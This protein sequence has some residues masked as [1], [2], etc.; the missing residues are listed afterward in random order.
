ML[1][2]N[3]PKAI[4]Y[5]FMTEMWERFSYYGIT[6]I[7]I[8]YMSKTFAIGKD[9]IY[10]IYGA[11]GA[12]VY[13]TPLIGGRIADKY[14]GSFNAVIIGSILIALGH[15]IV[16]I[17]SP[18]N[19]Y[20]YYGLA[21]IIIGTGLFMPNINAIVGHLYQ[22]KDPKRE[23]GFTLAYMGRNIGTILAPLV[24]S[25]VAALYSWRL[26]FIVAG[27]GMLIGLA[28]FLFGRRYYQARSFFQKVSMK[29]FSLTLALVILLSLVIF[30]F[31][32][33]YEFVGVLLVFIV[34][35]M[36][37]YLFILASREEQWQRNKIYFAMILTAF[38]IVFLILLQQSGGALNLFTDSFVYK[39]IWGVH[40]ETGAFQSIEPLALV[41]LTP[42]YNSLWTYLAKHK[43]T[44]SDAGKFAWA[45]VLMSSSFV[46]MA[47]AM[48]FT[49]ANG[50]I[51][52]HWINVTYVLQAAGELFIGPIGLAMV[53]RLI[54][55]HML[56][57]Y[58]GFWVLAS[59][60][61]NFIAAKIGALITPMLNQQQVVTHQSAISSYQTAFIELS[62]LGFLSVIGL[63][64]IMPKLKR[65]LDP[66]AA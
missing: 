35:L 1:F 5:L 34:S 32:E 41:M 27:F 58:M 2:K 37:L 15:F 4:P 3:Y 10:A 61:A 9:Q 33:H 13:M 20:F 55:Q 18:H 45:L 62:L 12:L 57:L 59:A 66:Q 47:I 8:L 29:T 48:N 38:Y 65:L 7:L 51:S 30:L 42:F 36:T 54:P 64:L 14:L 25:E 46:L 6:A 26:A 40:I 63:I 43:K 56:G 22:D 52:M 11:Y 49:N 50:L 31:M 44:F 19:H 39:E 16:A 60:V 24:A 53:S 28:I 21:V 23:N 17:P